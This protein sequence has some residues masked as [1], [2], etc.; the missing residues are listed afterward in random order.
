MLNGKSELDLYLEEP[1]LA[2]HKDLDV[3][4]YWRDC[5]RRFGDLGMTA[6][7]ILSIPITT[8]ASES[9]FS[10]GGRILSKYRS[11]M[12]STNLQALICTRNW[13]LGFSQN[14][15]TYFLSFYL[16]SLIIGYYYY[17]SFVL[18]YCIYLICRR[19][20]SS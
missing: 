5:S 15:K 2:G 13:L 17:V 20:E 4:E 10:I 14:G 19:I 8:V 11:S 6:R 9:A 1:K 3:L 16:T 12:L 7:D 18:I